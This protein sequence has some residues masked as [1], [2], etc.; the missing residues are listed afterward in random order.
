MQRFIVGAIANAGYRCNGRGSHGGHTYRNA[1]T[2]GYAYTHTLSYVHARADC[3]ADA[4][5]SSYAYSPTYGCAH[6][7]TYGYAHTQANSYIHSQANS[8][9]HSQ[10]NSYA[11]CQTNSY[12]YSQANDYAHT[13]P[14]IEC[15]GGACQAIRG[16]SSDRFW[17]RLRHD[18]R[19]GR[20]KRLYRHQLPCYSWCFTHC[21]HCQ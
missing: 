21:Y 19:C 16:L 5:T 7:Q 18:I 11:Y 10:A 6:A 14:F 2:H 9:I 12:A 13:T 8:Y 17:T 4:H 3:Y 20:C 1:A 15:D